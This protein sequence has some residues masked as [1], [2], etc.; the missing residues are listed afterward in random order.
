MKKIA[1]ILFAVL[2]VLAIA[3]CASPAPATP[4]PRPSD[5]TPSALPTQEPPATPKPTSWL[6]GYTVYDMSNMRPWQPLTNGVKSHQEKIYVKPDWS[7]PKPLE[8]YGGKYAHH[9]A[10]LLL[11]FQNPSDSSK[12]VHAGGAPMMGDAG[13]K[14]IINYVDPANHQTKI[15]LSTDEF[16]DPQTKT[17]ANTLSLGPGETKQVYMLCYITN[18]TYYDRYSGSIDPKIGLDANPAYVPM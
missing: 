10:I 5:T 7:M 13:V 2:A 4:T 14:S 1:V 16:Y 6:D 18:D 11:T 17:S 12:S 3:G 8:L 9:G 15:F